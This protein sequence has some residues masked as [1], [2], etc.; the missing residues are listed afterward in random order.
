VAQTPQDS[1]TT[2]TRLVEPEDDEWISLFNGRDL[3]GWS[4]DTAAWRVENGELIC[5]RFGGHAYL[6]H[7]GEY[8]DFE[9]QITYQVR[10]YANSGLIFRCKRLAPNRV[11]GIEAELRR[12]HSKSYHGAIVVC[13]GKGKIFDEVVSVDP[14]ACRRAEERSEDG[15]NR[16]VVRAQGSRIATEVNGVR[17][18]SLSDS[19]LRKTGRIAL[20]RYVGNPT[21]QIRILEL[22]LRKLPPDAS[23]ENDS[24]HSPRD[25]ESGEE[26]GPR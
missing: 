23:F 1:N 11:G 4:G 3:T 13:R 20:Q 14:E 17:L 5:V 6:F 18:A 25:L 2:A 22:R 12:M 9:L 15:W 16:M 24:D 21:G 8:S 19:T 10:D 26:G 7:A